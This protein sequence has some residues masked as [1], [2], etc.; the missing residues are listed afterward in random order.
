MIIILFSIFISN[1]EI[2]IEAIQSHDKNPPLFPF[3][4]ITIACGAISGFHGLVS[5]GT[6]SKQLNNLKDSRMIGYG[7][8]LGEGSLALLTTVAAVCGVG[9]Y[10]NIFPE[11]SHDLS[12]FASAKNIGLG[13]HHRPIFSPQQNKYNIGHGV[14]L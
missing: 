5:S 3:I 8:A 6:T 10:L 12:H 9:I 13:L 7:S 2:A 14:V 4:F 11:H 1:P